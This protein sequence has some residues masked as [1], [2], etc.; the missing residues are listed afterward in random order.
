MSEFLLADG[1][2]AGDG[3]GV[4]KFSSGADEEGEPDTL[5]PGFVDTYLANVLPSALLLFLLWP[6]DDDGNESM[7][8][9]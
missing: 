5:V 7:L 9:T 1:V 3:L 4:K 8:Y 2:G 6:S